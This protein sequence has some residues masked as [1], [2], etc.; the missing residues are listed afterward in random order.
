[1][2]VDPAK[3]EAWKT[4]VETLQRFY[5]IV[6]A[7][8]LTSALSKLIGILEGA[9]TAPDRLQA[10][11]L[12]A[13]F[14]STIVPFYHGMERH[15]YDTHR[16]LPELGKGGRPFPLLADIF[17][18]IIEGSIL[19]AM[20]RNLDNTANFLMLWSM[21]LVVDVVWSFAVW[22]VQRGKRPAW[23]LNNVAWLI[24]AW[25][26]WFSLPLVLSDFGFAASE[27]LWLI[28]VFIA[29]IEISRSIADYWMNWRFYFPDSRNWL[30]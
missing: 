23:I 13:A 28:P 9:P 3:A 27:F 1:M 8:A 4:T 10:I 7:I 22:H 24:L 17:V 18:F 12:A 15:L 6:I 26:A 30:A 21:L 2:S 11:A 19:F 5:S 25:V 16:V 14:L 29:V 20:G